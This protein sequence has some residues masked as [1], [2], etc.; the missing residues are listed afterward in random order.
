MIVEPAGPLLQATKI[1]FQPAAMVENL[2]Q[3]SHVQPSWGMCR[4]LLSNLLAFAPPNLPRAA[5][6]PLER[7]MLPL[8]GVVGDAGDELLQLT[9]P[10]TVVSVAD[11]EPGSE[12]VKQEVAFES[13]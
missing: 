6:A 9:L 13:S 2:I 11:F 8:T 7:L 4:L 5:V 1:V 10:V 12:F 3:P